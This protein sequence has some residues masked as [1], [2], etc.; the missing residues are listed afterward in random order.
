MPH[1]TIAMLHNRVKKEILDSVEGENYLT[2]G[3]YYIL[4][5]IINF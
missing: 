4:L 1:L 2:A 5:Y 3:F